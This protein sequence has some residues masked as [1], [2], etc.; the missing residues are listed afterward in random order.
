ML[1]VRRMV[2]EGRTVVSVIHQPPSEV[3]D[4]FDKLLLLSE[5]R[6]VYF[7]DANKA[8]ITFKEAGLVK[9]PNQGEQ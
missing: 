4:L 5:G 6:M 7:G 9:P 1:A 3:Y 8:S 2:E